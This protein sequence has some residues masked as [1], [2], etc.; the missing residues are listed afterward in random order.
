MSTNEIAAYVGRQIFVRVLEDILKLAYLDVVS[1][2]YIYPNP[3]FGRMEAVEITFSGGEKRQVC[4]EAD[5]RAAIIKDILRA[6]EYP[7]HAR[8]RD[9]EILL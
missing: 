8:R 2:R 4:I 6:C 7:K 1:L 9:H 3:E 5:S